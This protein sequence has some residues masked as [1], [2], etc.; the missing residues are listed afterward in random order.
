LAKCDWMPG[1]RYVLPEMKTCICARLFRVR[2]EGIVAKTMARK[3]IIKGLLR[4]LLFVGAG[5]IGVMLLWRLLLYTGEIVQHPGE[6]RYLATPLEIMA[7]SYLVLWGLRRRGVGLGRS[8]STVSAALKASAVFYIAGLLAIFVGYARFCSLAGFIGAAAYSLKGNL[9]TGNLALPRI[10]IFTPAVAIP[11][12]GLGAL[13]EL[14]MGLC[15]PPEG[16]I[17]TSF[18]VH[19]DREAR[20]WITFSQRRPC[21]RMGS[22]RRHAE[23]VARILGSRM[24]SVDGG[25]GAYD[26]GDYIAARFSKGYLLDPSK[27]IA[28]TL[29]SI[30]G[31]GRRGVRVAAQF[32]W[33]T[34]KE[35][36]SAR[37]LLVAL[38]NDT[39]AFSKFESDLIRTVPLTGFLDAHT[40]IGLSK[41]IKDRGLFKIVG[42]AYLRGSLP[43]G[44]AYEPTCLLDRVVMRGYVERG[45]RG[46]KSLAF[47]FPE[48]H[49][50]LV[51]G[52]SSGKTRFAHDL[53][54]S[55]TEMNAV[56][57]II[58]PHEEYGVRRQGSEGDSLNPFKPPHGVDVL[59]HAG[60][61][62]V[63]SPTLASAFGVSEPQEEVAK[64]IRSDGPSLK[65]YLEGMAGKVD[66]ENVRVRAAITQLAEETGIDE[67]ISDTA[68][69]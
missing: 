42:E 43:I 5:I 52:K 61:L 55:L 62:L 3:G 31:I 40:V 34:F 46:A 39:Q 2:A 4:S 67:L 51:G 48:G 16:D 24:R 33:A 60:S 9:V 8:F 36:I 28:E 41:E 69:P 23:N 19:L 54:L 25:E 18:S 45:G 57:M 37:H 10:H 30:S 26:I 58:D 6:I 27:S 22:F 38:S 32:T 11:V 21:I 56:V 50:L 1:G 20:S 44:M 17:V 7:M 13:N 14:S 66:E 65:G 63:F 49:V 64:V 12:P 15:T 59:T 29:K 35:G 68:L 53:V 47:P